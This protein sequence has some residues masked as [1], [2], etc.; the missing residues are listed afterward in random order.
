MAELLLHLGYTPPMD[1][2]R[3]AAATELLL[4]EACLELPRTHFQHEH[5]EAAAE[6]LLY[7]LTNGQDAE[8]SFWDKLPL[9]EH[10]KVALARH[11]E[12][13]HGWA[14]QALWKQP[15]AALRVAAATGWCPPGCQGA[16]QAAAPRAATPPPAP[17]AP[18]A[19]GPGRGRGGRAGA[20]GPGAPAAP[21][22]APW[23][24]TPGTR[25]PLR[26]QTAVRFQKNRRGQQEH[27]Q[28]LDAPWTKRPGDEQ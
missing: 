28:S 11:L 9:E 2:A 26:R 1:A 8:E 24:R 22:R 21:G 7:R 20:A 16:P 3:S 25:P 17:P 10:T 14:R 13:R 27:K 5:L 15:L 4:E 19:P 23:T 12:R 6:P 18:R